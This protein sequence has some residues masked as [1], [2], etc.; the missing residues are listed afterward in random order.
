LTGKENPP[1]INRKNKLKGK[2][3]PPRNELKGL[4]GK[5]NSSIISWQNKPKGLAGKENPLP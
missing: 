4:A 1:I 3:N 2:E 5:E